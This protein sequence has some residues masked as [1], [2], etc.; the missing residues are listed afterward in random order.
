MDTLEI[1]TFFHEQTCTAT[2][3]V[4]SQ[5]RAAIIDSALDYDQASGRTASKAAD[6]IISYVQQRD[7]TVDWILETHVHADHL[8]AAPYLRDALGGTVGIGNQVCAVQKT[9]QD[10]YNLHDGFMSDGS[11]FDHLFKDGETFELGG[12]NATV[13]H[14]PG[15]TPACVSY[16]IGDA[17]FVGDTLFMPDFGTARCDFPGGDAG[18]LYR[19]IRRI[20][21]LPPET[22]VFV[23]HDYAPG[24]RGYEWETTVAQERAENKHVKDGIDEAEFTAM[25]STRDAELSMPGLILPAVQV[26]IRG[27]DLPPVEDNGVAYLKIP[28]NAL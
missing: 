11:Q 3:V 7:F 5:G 16:H 1:R 24:D 14:T 20:L 26:N 12:V 28:L 13:L 15:H 8:T 9:F 18:T 17:V 10:V 2:Y 22:R 4:A 19:S 27:G 21:D 6:E 25:R 23:G